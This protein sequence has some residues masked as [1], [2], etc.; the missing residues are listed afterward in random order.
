MNLF[1][2]TSKVAVHVDDCWVIQ[3]WLLESSSVLYCCWWLL[4]PSSSLSSS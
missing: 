2:D 4:Y 3:E 1:L